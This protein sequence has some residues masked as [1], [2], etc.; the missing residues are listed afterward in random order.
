MAFAKTVATHVSNQTVAKAT[1]YALSSI[2]A[3]D[4]STAIGAADVEG[5]CTYHSSATAGAIV[6]VYASSDNSNWGS[7]PVDQFTMPFKA[8]TTKRWSKTIIPSAKYL[9]CTIY[10]SDAAQN[11]TASYVYLTYQTGP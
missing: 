10:N 3:T 5:V 6:R 4:M 2:T 1:E 11:I 8:N 7:S 9:K